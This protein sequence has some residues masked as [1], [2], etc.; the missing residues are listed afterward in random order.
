MVGTMSSY[1]FDERMQ[2]PL[3][4]HDEFLVKH[5]PLWYRTPFVQTVTLGLVFFFVFTSYTTIQFYARSTY[6][7]ELAANSVSAVYASFTLACLVAPAIT[8]MLGSQITLCVGILGYAALVAASLVY[9]VANAGGDGGAH[10]EPRMGWLVVVGGAILGCGASLLWTAQGRLLL[11]YA[12]RAEELADNLATNDEP[13]MKATGVK[14]SKSQTGTL[15]GVFWAVFQ[16]SSLVG[17]AMSLVYYSQKPSGSILLYAIFLGFILVG[18]LSTQVLLPPCLLIV[19]TPSATHTITEVA[20][21]SVAVTEKTALVQNSAN[22]LQGD[23]A[24]DVIGRISW[25]QQ[26]TCTLQVFCTKPMLLLSALF[27]YTGLINLTNNRPLG[28][29]S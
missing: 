22:V 18:A 23:A 16:C 5:T 6:G 14:T 7:E 19:G 9:F 20:V 8:N 12:A 17:G 21:G 10:Q 1:L 11:Q 13:S 15:L 4:L 28:I 27:F 3:S 26:V 2:P 29:D 25:W 24:T